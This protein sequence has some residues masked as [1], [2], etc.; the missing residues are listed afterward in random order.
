MTRFVLDSFGPSGLTVFDGGGEFGDVKVRG[1]EGGVRVET[2]TE[3]ESGEPLF[4]V[5]EE[6]KGRK[7]PD[8]L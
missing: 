5:V 1:R 6:A 7:V 2:A 4:D 3:V 8:R